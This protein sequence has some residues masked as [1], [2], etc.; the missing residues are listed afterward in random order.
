L[1]EAKRISLVTPKGPF[2]FPKLTGPDYGNENFPKPDG[3][4]VTVRG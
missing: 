4:H 2:R 3:D 1:I